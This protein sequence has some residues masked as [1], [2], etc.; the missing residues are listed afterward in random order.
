MIERQS[1]THEIKEAITRD[2]IRSQS[3]EGNELNKK[4]LSNVWI[5]AMKFL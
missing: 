4:P 2:V 5:T 1:K 3:E